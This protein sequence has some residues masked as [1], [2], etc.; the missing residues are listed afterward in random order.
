MFGRLLLL[1]I[2]IPLLEL[3]ILVWLGS[4]IGF[5]PTMA[6]V[7]V[8]GILGA[9]LAR[10]E[11]LRVVLQIRAELLGGRMP[12]GQLLD[13]LMVLIG[14]VVLLTPG[15]LTDLLGFSLLIPWTR[16]KFKRF[17]RRRFE[18]MRQAR[19]INIRLML[20]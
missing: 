16:S 1:F 15:L 18:R 13:G 9:L 20:D 2:G 14:G 17:V 6:I 12:V 8:T 19:Q 3:A 5:W 11:G 4:H 10:L 7:L